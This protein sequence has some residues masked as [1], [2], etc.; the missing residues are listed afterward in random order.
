MKIL[1]A[2]ENLITLLAPGGK[3]IVTLPLG[4]NLVMDKLLREGKI[5]FTKQFYLKRI[6]RDN[7]WKEVDW[8]DVHYVRYYRHIPSAYGLVIGIIE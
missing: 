1:C 4:Y 3:L 7:K 2:F 8:E 6:S 5:S